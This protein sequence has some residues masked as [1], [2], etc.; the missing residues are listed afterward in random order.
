MSVSH[1]KTNWHHEAS[2]IIT[3]TQNL[4]MSGVTTKQGTGKKRRTGRGDKDT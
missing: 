2:F 1:Q 3:T 4:K